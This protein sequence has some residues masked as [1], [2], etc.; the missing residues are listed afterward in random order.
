MFSY[1]NSVSLRPTNVQPLPFLTPSWR[2]P[3][4]INPSPRPPDPVRQPP[5]P[6][7]SPPT[8]FQR[9]SFLT[10]SPESPFFLPRP[11]QAARPSPQNPPTIGPCPPINLLCMPYQAPL[12]PP[13]H[14][15]LSA[16]PPNP[17]GLRPCMS[18]K[19]HASELSFAAPNS[20][21]ST[22]L[23]LARMSLQPSINTELF[24]F[25]VF[26]FFFS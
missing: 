13:S 4:A 14:R 19:D 8:L 1:R 21:N 22:C 16:I 9:F 10:S 25:F 18:L 26:C 23:T 15:K 20:S 11:S 7:P 6:E 12:K 17:R 3:F 2:A 24:L 5:F